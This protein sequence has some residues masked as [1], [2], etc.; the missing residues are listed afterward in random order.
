MDR[1][2]N[3]LM[4]VVSSGALFFSTNPLH[5]VAIIACFPLSLL[6]SF[7]IALHRVAFITCLLYRCLFVC[8]SLICLQDL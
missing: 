6:C 5:D 1:R 7:D 3:G 8:F 2:R 4:L